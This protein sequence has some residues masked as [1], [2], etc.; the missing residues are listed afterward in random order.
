MKRNEEMSS[1]DVL[2]LFI[3]LPLFHSIKSQNRRR[4]FQI[5]FSQVPCLLLFKCP[6]EIFISLSLALSFSPSLSLSHTHSLAPF[7]S[8][9]CWHTHFLSLTNYA[10]TCLDK[11][12]FSFNRKYMHTYTARDTHFPLSLY[13]TPPLTH[14]ANSHTRFRR[15]SQTHT[16]S[17]SLSL[18][19]SLSRTH[20]DS[21]FKTF[22]QLGK[23]CLFE[24]IAFYFN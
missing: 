4:A 3:F 5:S 14:H 2:L 20:S 9:F 19:L 6:G 24:M 22:R 13:C 10:L 21:S 1:S 23:E 7:L 15:C 18:S 17:L 16:H 12:S 11:H 8:N